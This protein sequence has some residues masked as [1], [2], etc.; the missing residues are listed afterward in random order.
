MSGT[1]SSL[2]KEKR[3]KEIF[4]VA[5]RGETRYRV[6]AQG[7]GDIISPVAAKNASSAYNAKRTHSAYRS[8]VRGSHSRQA[9]HEAAIMYLDKQLAKPTS[10]PAPKPVSAT[11]PLP[12]TATKTR[13]PI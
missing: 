10:K 1:D 3:I 9:L 11:K 12:P 13:P 4:N 8:N 6:R 5:R 2:S 7:R